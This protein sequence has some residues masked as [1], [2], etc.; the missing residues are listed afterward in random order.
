MLPT[1]GT[2]ASRA[3]TSPTGAHARE[4]IL[5]YIEDEPVNALLV[6]ESLRAHPHLKLILAPDGPTGLALARALRPAIVLSDI[7]LPGLSGLEVVRALRADG[8]APPM[9]CIALSADAMREQIDAALEAGFDDY[10]TKPVDLGSVPAR[11][12][13]WLRT[14]RRPAATEEQE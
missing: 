12:D 9:V 6:Q 13:G 3:D 11:I 10:W 5:L 4:A 1:A 7:N 2:I 14:G 8:L